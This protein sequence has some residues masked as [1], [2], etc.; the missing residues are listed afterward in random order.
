MFFL[1]QSSKI[2]MHGLVP[3]ENLN[4]RAVIKVQNMLIVSFS[5][6]QMYKLTNSLVGIMS[7]SRI[8]RFD[9][10]SSSLDKNGIRIPAAMIN[11]KL[12]KFCVFLKTQPLEA[13]CS[14]HKEA[15]Q[16]CFREV[17]S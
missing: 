17:H 12:E 16:T 7:S 9:H 2:I 3:T 1:T 6:M 4:L 14:D 15:T 5:L 11:G 10:V 8:M 13:Y